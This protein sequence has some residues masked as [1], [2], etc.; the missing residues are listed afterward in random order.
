MKTKTYEIGE[1]RVLKY[2]RKKEVITIS[3]KKTGTESRIYTCSLGVLSSLH[4]RGGR[5]AEQFIA[6]SRCGLLHSLRWRMARLRDYRL[7]VRRLVKVVRAVRQDRSHTDQDGHRTTSV[8]M[9]CVQADGPASTPRLPGRCQL[10]GVLS[11]SS[12]RPSDLHGMQPIS[13]PAV[14]SSSMTD[15]ACL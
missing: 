13:E 4:R 9:V 8:R 14:N 1:N 10:H 3:D 12:T 6:R 15:V 5:S 11:Q 2:N 7:Q